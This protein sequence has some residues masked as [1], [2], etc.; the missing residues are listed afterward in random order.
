MKW[1]FTLE[2]KITLIIQDQEKISMKKYLALIISFIK[3]FTKVKLKIIIYSPHI[4][5]VEID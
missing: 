3:Y 4:T 5:K 2:I 1:I